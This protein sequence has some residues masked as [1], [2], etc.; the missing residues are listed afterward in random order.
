MGKNVMWIEEEKNSSSSPKAGK[1][2]VKNGAP[3]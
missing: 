2:K 1:V 3:I